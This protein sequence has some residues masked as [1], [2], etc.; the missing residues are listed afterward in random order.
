MINQYEAKVVH[1][2][3]EIVREHPHTGYQLAEQKAARYLSSLHDQLKSQSYVTALTADIHEWKKKHIRRFS[4]LSLWSPGKKKPDTQDY[5]RYIQWLNYTK[6][7]DDYLDRSV[8]YIYMRD[9]GKAPDSPD[10]QKRIRRTIADLNQHLLKSARSGSGEVPDFINL[11]GVYRWAQKEGIE[12]AVI[13]VFAKLRS[14]AAHIPEGMNAEHAQRKLIKII[15]GVILHVIEEMNEDTAPVERSRRLDEAIRLGYSYGLT[16]PFVDDLLDSRI[17]TVQEKEQYSELIRSALLTGV[18]PVLGGWSGENMELIKYIHSELSEAFE[19]IKQQQRPETQH[20][21]FGQSYVFFQAQDIDRVKVL[22]RGDY[23]N[24]D[25]YIPVILKSSSSRL[26]ARSVISAPADEGFEERTFFFGLYNQLADDFA[27]MTEDMSDGAVTPY[28]YYLKYHKQRPDLINPFE[29]Y[30]A[31]I[32][33]LI[34][35]VYHSDAKAR[36]VILDRAINGLKRYKERVGS[37]KYNETMRIFAAGNPEFNGL[38]QIMVDKADDVDFFDKLLRDRMIEHLKKDAREQKEF[39]VTFKSV[40]SLINEELLFAKPQE[41]PAMKEQLIDAA[42]YSLAGD[43]KR[44]RPI[45]TWVMGVK[46]Y[47]LEP[48]A[49]VPLLRSLEYMHT[50][51]LIFD[52]LPSQDNASTRRGRTTLHE[53]HSSAVAE[54]TGLYLIQKAIGEQAS[55]DRFKA[56]TVLALIR[57][58]ARKAEEMCMGQAMDLDAKGRTLTLEQLNNVCFYKTG[59]A[60]EA[61]LVMP[62]MLAEVSEAEIAALKKIAYHMGIAFQIKD[63]LLDVEGDMHVLGKPVGNDVVNNNSNFV[64]ILG[65]EGASKE[66]WDHYCKANEALRRIPRN[67]TFL[68][69]LMN[70]V[71]NR[72]R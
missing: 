40:R 24:D 65:Q 28:T 33:N 14:V 64:S 16:Y 43:G 32:S 71:V 19:Y 67:I 68:K 50:A 72:E 51:S 62:A 60:F 53:I 45:L 66:M 49:I 31:V 69:H 46:E 2:M 29:L 10:T 30:W 1:P 35:S 25:L 3:N 4:V 54:L 44:V 52:D 18:V 57:Y 55:L 70:Y 27:D 37:D 59:V 11:D 58:S 12:A 47:G 15:V 7:L 34:H 39:F 63:D 20:I 13:W 56:E 5:Y 26:I 36:E 6:K 48:A 17:L 21:F 22:T 38:I 42:N 9:L 23:T 8:S 41:L 61:C